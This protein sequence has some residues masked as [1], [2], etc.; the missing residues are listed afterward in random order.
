[1]NF[2]KHKAIW[3]G[4]IVLIVIM[5]GVTWSSVIM[6]ATDKVHQAQA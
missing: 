5:L 4:L 1:M 3:I 2:N 6:P